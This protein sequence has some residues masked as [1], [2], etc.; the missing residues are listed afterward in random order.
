MLAVDVTYFYITVPIVFCVLLTV[1]LSISS[2]SLFKIIHIG[3]EISD[4]C[5][6]EYFFFFGS[7]PDGVRNM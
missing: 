3:F 2:W 4:P 6:N 5:N 1:Y 7:L